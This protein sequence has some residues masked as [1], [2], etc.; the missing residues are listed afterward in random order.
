[1]T[2]GRRTCGAKLAALALAITVVG[3]A[4]TG[5]ADDQ[6]GPIV[7]GNNESAPPFHLDMPNAVF[8][9]DYLYEHDT[10]QQQGITAAGKRSEE[11]RVG[12]ECH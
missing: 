6:G 4:A 12:K 2:A 1:M 3:S 8:N 9:F 7:V 11:R 5:L 10:N